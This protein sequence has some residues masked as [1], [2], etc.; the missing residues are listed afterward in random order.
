MTR[1][2]QRERQVRKLLEDEGWWVCR[3]AGSRGDADLVAL[4]RGDALLVEVKST[5]R[6][7]YHGFGPAQREELR[8]AADQAGAVATLCWWPSRKRPTW[9]NEYDW[10][11]HDSLEGGDE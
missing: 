7:P 10:P 11:K 3:A 8:A 4:K 9:I 1:G 2:I 5:A 6:G